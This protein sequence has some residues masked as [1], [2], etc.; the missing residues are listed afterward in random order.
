MTF[1]LG[2]KTMLQVSQ[3]IKPGQFIDYRGN[4]AKVLRV[5]VNGNEFLTFQLE[6]FGED[7][8][9]KHYEYN[10]TIQ[11]LPEVK[12]WMRGVDTKALPFEV[13]LEIGNANGTYSNVLVNKWIA[14]TYPQL[15]KTMTLTDWRKIA[16]KLEYSNAWAIN[17]YAEVQDMI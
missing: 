5:D 9:T 6:L 1:I 16:E 15:L 3:E 2:I 14:H 10:T 17:K 7:K 11:V 8:I 13:W 4:A 12:E